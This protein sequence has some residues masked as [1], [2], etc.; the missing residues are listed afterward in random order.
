MVKCADNRAMYVLCYHP[1]YTFVE[2]L[3][4]I[5]TKFRKQQE[6]GDFPYN[7]LRHYYDVYC[8]LDEPY[9]IQFIGT[10]DYHLYKARRFR[11]ENTDITTNEAFVVIIVLLA[12]MKKHTR[13]QSHSSTKTV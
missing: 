2:K 1:G 12:P 4:A 9:V 6:E 8:L 10:E 5:S 3:Q 11:S 7:F 13:I